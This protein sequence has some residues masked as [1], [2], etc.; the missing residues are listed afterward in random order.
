MARVKTTGITE[1]SFDSNRRRIRVYDHGGMR[2]ERKKWIH[3][4]EKVDVIIFHVEIASYDQVLFEDDTVNRIKEALALFDSI[5]NSRWFIKTSF[6]LHFTKMDKLEAKIKK[7]PLKNYFPDFEK[8]GRNIDDVKAYIESR[9][10]SL[11]QHPEK[12]VQVIYTSFIT[13]YMAD[14]GKV[15]DSIS[16]LYYAI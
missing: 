3:T 5:V 13:E 6:L 1:T 8:D 10:L 4:F 15:F 7:S 12:I 16:G 9:F 2:S 14:F 11:N